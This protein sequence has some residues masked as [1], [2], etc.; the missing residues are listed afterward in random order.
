[1]PWRY[2]S[3]YANWTLVIKQGKARDVRQIHLFFIFLHLFLQ[4]KL[5]VTTVK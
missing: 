1:M 5:V 3:F 4:M 2:I